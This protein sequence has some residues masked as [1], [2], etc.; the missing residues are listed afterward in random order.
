M[1]TALL[2]ALTVSVDALGVGLSFGMRGIR[3][4]T[5]AKLIICIFSVI[6]AY[7]A[8]LFG[9][10][11]ARVL[12]PAVSTV[13]GT[14]LLCLMG[15]YI[16]WDRG[17]R[18]KPPECGEQEL[19]RCRRQIQ[20]VIKSLGI[21]VCIIRNPKSG[22]VDHSGAIDGKEA[23]ALGLALSVD[24]LGAGLGIALTGAA[25]WY[26]PLLVGGAQMAFLYLGCFCGDRL[27]RL[28]HERL[29]AV[30]SGLIL[31]IIGLLRLF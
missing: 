26:F 16:I 2:L 17:L 30:L 8:V 23:L 19:K 27:K 31:I 7:A 28:L 12:P 1:A 10:V 14:G 29:I 4:Q 15:L 13:I 3:I 20:W 22:D 6:Y 24:V 5:A 9:G 25:G 11:L 18:T 21:T